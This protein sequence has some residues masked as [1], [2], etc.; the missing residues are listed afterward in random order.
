MLLKFVP[1]FLIIITLALGNRMADQ[2]NS[3]RQIVEIERLNL[4]E[5]AGRSIPAMSN[6]HSPKPQRTMRTR[7]VPFFGN[8]NFVNSGFNIQPASRR[9]SRQ[10]SS[11]LTPSLPLTKHP[12][13]PVKKPI[14]TLRTLLVDFDKYF[15]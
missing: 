6:Q 4:V 15:D 12:L 7:P 1:F 2:S 9:A 3:T 14:T 11:T 5:G 13:P 8:Q 10:R